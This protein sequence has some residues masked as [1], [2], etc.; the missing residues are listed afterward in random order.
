MRRQGRQPAKCHPVRPVGVTQRAHHYVCFSGLGWSREQLDVTR[1]FDPAARRLTFGI[2]S[3]PPEKLACGPDRNTRDRSPVDMDALHL[4][5]TRS[6]DGNSDNSL[7]EVLTFSPDLGLSPV[8]SLSGNMDHLNCMDSISPRR[9]L[10]LSPDSQNPSPGET[11]LHTTMGTAAFSDFPIES[12]PPQTCSTSDSS[13]EYTIHKPLKKA[14]RRGNVRDNVE[15]KRQTDTR[16]KKSRMKLSELFHS[17]ELVI[18]QQSH[19]TEEIKEGPITRRND[20]TKGLQDVSDN[21]MFMVNDIS[22][23]LYSADNEEDDLISDLSKRYSLP[24]EGGKH[25]DLRYITSNTLANLLEGRYKDTVEKYYVVDC[26][27]PYE[28]AGGHIKEAWNLYKEEHISEYFLKR[29]PLP[30]SRTVLIFHCEFSSERAPKLCRI[31]RNL[32]RK[33]NIYPHLYYPE[34]YL[35]KGGYKEFYE[36]VKDLC[37]PQGYVNMLHSD[38]TDQLKKYHTKKKPPSGQRVRKELFK[39]LNSHKRLVEIQ[40]RLSDRS[41]KLEEISP[42]EDADNRKKLRAVLGSSHFI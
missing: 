7:D 35:L 33:E 39:P 19:R 17:P 38:F 34:L 37:E 36:N 42:S 16:K 28:Y 2:R 6:E 4:I 11:P 12:T 30:E 3:G 18:M 1:H 41:R 26:R 29:P 8:T 22:P 13:L 5:S 10:K 25:Q 15:N 23:T 32:D 21:K 9:R 31:L 14:T 24:V 20:K 27:Y 40:T